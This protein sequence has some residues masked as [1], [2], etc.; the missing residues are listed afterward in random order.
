MSWTKFYGPEAG[1]TRCDRFIRCLGINSIVINNVSCRSM[2]YFY[3]K[4]DWVHLWNEQLNA[5]IPF[6]SDRCGFVLC[7]SSHWKYYSVGSIGKW[8]D[9]QTMEKWCVTKGSLIH[10]RWE[11]VKV[12]RELLP[13]KI[14]LE[15]TIPFWR[16]Q[17]RNTELWDWD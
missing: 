3:L 4:K 11:N 17:I 6:V 5:L 16:N 9:N 7:L 13:L 12:W 8:Q 15:V 1:P 14:I 2:H 10:V